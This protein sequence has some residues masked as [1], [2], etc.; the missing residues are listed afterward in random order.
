MAEEQQ[1]RARLMEQGLGV[2]N[3]G[4][5]ESVRWLNLLFGAAPSPCV[6]VDVSFFFAEEGALCEVGG[7]GTFCSRGCSL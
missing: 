5:E 4:G 7:K 2:S 1:R 6:D 3:G